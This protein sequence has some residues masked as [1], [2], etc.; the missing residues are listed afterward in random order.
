MALLYIDLDQFKAYNDQ[1]GFLRGDEAIEA[2]VG[3]GG[4]GAV[5]LASHKRL[6]GKKVAIKE[7]KKRHSEPMKVQNPTFQE[8]SP[9]AL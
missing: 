7:P 1:Y 5:F 2:L 8:G 6:P 3:H 9:V 4:M